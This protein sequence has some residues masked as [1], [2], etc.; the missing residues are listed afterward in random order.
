MSDPFGRR[1]GLKE[2]FEEFH[3]ENPDIYE[4]FERFTFKVIATGRKH[5]TAT[6]VFERV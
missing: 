2:Q 4:A 3:A 5:Y 6:A 1:K